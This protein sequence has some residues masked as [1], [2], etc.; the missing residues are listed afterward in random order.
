MQPLLLLLAAPINLNKLFVLYRNERSAV[1]ARAGS[2][3]ER[4]L[5][6]RCRSLFQGLVDKTAYKK[7]YRR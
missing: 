7:G 2:L 4:S 6:A 3:H 1:D 5:T